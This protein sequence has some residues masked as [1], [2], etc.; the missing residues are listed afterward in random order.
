MPI[1]Y[2]M[3]V[4]RNHFWGGGGGGWLGDEV[5]VCVCVCV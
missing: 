4:V 3:C 1:L 5:C 2:I